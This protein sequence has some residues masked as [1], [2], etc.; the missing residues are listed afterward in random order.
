MTSERVL[1]TKKR[2]M[3]QEGQGQDVEL[4]R[5][6]LHDTD[7]GAVGQPEERGSDRPSKRR[8]LDLTTSAAKRFAENS[9]HTLESDEINAGISCPPTYASS[10]REIPSSLARA[11]SCQ[12]LSSKRWASEFLHTSQIHQIMHLRSLSHHDVDILDND[13]ITQ[14]KKINPNCEARVV[15][16]VSSAE[17]LRCEWQGTLLKRTG[18]V[19]RS[20]QPRFCRLRVSSQEHKAMVRHPVLEYTSKSKGRRFLIIKDVRREHELDSD[21]QFGLSLGLVCDPGDADIL[22]DSFP[23]SSS[24]RRVMLMAQSDLE[25]VAL[26]TCLRRILEPGRALPTLRDAMHFPLQ[27]LRMLE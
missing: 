10:G 15:S 8:R 4:S 22:L 21:L 5:I 3:A 24:Q 7:D 20:W 11:D 9:E 18:T 13:K 27:A 26:L 1:E 16:A 25:A 23:L 12:I 19:I 6:T 17:H 2:N 14:S